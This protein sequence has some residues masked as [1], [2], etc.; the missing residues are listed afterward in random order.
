M[1]FIANDNAEKK[2]KEILEKEAFSKKAD[3][4][5]QLKRLDIEIQQ[6]K[7]EIEKNKDALS[8]LQQFQQFILELTPDEFKL[9]RERKIQARKD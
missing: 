7:S 6:V 5:E 1:A 9:E 2:K 8:G 3:K 4:D